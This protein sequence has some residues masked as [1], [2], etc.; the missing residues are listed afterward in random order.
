MYLRLKELLVALLGPVFVGRDVKF[1]Q[2][3]SLEVGSVQE[4]DAQRTDRIR[5]KIERDKLKRLRPL[6]S[7]SGHSASKVERALTLLRV[8][9]QVLPTPGERY[10]SVRG[11]G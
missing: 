10:I 2:N 1:Y 3:E 7:L 11:I 4:R 8:L 6:P 9:I 5:L